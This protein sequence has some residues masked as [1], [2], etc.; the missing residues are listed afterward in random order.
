MIF[1]WNRAELYFAFSNFL[2]RR[3]MVRS[4]LND[5]TIAISC[6]MMKVFV[7]HWGLASLVFSFYSDAIMVFL[8]LSTHFGLYSISTPL[9]CNM[10]EKL[11]FSDLPVGIEA[12]HRA[13]MGYTTVKYFGIFNYVARNISRFFN[14]QHYVLDPTG[15]FY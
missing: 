6:S 11:W 3:N 10:S 8:A 15:T 4:T 2:L 13:K 14:F 12:E 5:T 7:S 9:P 1:I